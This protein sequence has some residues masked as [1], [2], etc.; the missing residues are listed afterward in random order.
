MSLQDEITCLN[1][2]LTQ[3]RSQLEKEKKAST[4]VKLKKAFLSNPFKNFYR[5]CKISNGN[6]LTTPLY[7]CSNRLVSLYSHNRL[8][9][10]WSQQTCHLA[11][12]QQTCITTGVC[13]HGHNRLVSPWSQQACVTTSLCHHGH[14]R[15]RSIQSQQTSVTNFG[16]VYMI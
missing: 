3:I 2:K 15:P 10:P 1:S 6:K 13:H 12:S 4:D 7:H 8:V 11:R 5:T 9:S 16:P 14:Y